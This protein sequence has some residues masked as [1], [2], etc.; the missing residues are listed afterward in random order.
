MHAPFNPMLTR[1]ID[2]DHDQLLVVQDRPGTRIDVYFGGLWLTEERQ[3]QDRFVTPRATAQLE[4]SGR[5][6]MQAS[7]LT[8]V[9]LIEPARRLGL[10]GWWRLLHGHVRSV[11]AASPAARASVVLM[12]VVVGL[13][14]PETVA[15]GFLHAGALVG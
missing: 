10:G 1:T 11:V 2:L 3:L 6:V 8:R 12:A 15:R 13:G 4:A 7:G 9:R 14:L 5:A